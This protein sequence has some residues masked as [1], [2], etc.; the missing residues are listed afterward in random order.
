MKPKYLPQLCGSSKF[1]THYLIHLSKT[2]IH[3]LFFVNTNRDFTLG[4]LKLSEYFK[5]EAVSQGCSLQSGRITTKNLSFTMCTAE[6][7]MGSILKIIAK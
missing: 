2:K 3:D 4:D 6:Q 5:K 7:V 1:I